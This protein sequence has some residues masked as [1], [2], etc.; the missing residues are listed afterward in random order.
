MTSVP[1]CHVTSQLK[2]IFTYYNTKE[3]RSLGKLH[4]KH[5]A[6]SIEHITVDTTEIQRDHSYTPKKWIT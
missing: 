2:E 4:R 5:L 1:L 6:Q 3:I